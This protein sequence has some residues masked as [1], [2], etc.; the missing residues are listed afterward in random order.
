MIITENNRNK[1]NSK[2]GVHQHPFFVVKNKKRLLKKQPRKSVALPRRL[3]A[4][5]RICKE[6][7]LL[8]FAADGIASVHYL[9]C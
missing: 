3:G 5:D 8:R 9:E 1:T 7:A 2:R 4:E 6:A